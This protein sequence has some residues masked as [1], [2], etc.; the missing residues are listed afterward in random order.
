MNL[1]DIVLYFSVAGVAASI[2]SAAGGGTFLVFPMLMFGG[3]T[4]I[5]ANVTSTIALWPGSVVSAVTYSKKHR[6]DMKTLYPLLM[7]SAMGGAL[8]TL[9]LLDTPDLVFKSLVPWLL[10]GATLIFTFGQQAVA[11][12]RKHS[13]Q[14]HE[15]LA[16]IFQFTIAMYGGYFGAGIGILML[17]MLQIMGHSEI[18]QMNGIKSLL[19]S[20]IN[21]VAVAIFLFSGKIIWDVAAVLIAGAMF[22]GYFG[23]RLALKISPKKI[24]LMV[25]AIGFSM[26]AYFFLYGV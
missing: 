4:P 10:L 5:A 7:V 17:A 14:K 21:A 12:L 23:T 19:G 3:L 18:H 25:S 8:G 9:I 1:L 16:G 22:G 2:N 20:T 24:R 26:A 6:Y 15:L 13:G 11:W